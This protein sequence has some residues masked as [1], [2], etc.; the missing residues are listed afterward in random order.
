[1][2]R[3]EYEVLARWARRALTGTQIEDLSATLAANFPNFNSS[4]FLLAAGYTANMIAEHY[5]D[6]LS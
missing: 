2:S 6:Q 3:S 5:R 1:M 4:R